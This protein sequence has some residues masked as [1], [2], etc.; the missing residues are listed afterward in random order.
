MPIKESTYTPPFFLT[1]GHTQ[2]LY[3]T[4]FRKIKPNFEYRV[5][6]VTPDL[7]F[8]DVDWKKI[9]SKKCV[10]LSHGMEGNSKKWYISAMSQHFTDHDFDVCAW[11]FR[12]CSGEPNVTLS[13]YHSGKTEDLDLVIQNAINDYDEIYLV[14]F[15]MGGNIS[16]KYVGE[17][18]DT[19][20]PKIKKCAV[21]SVPVDLYGSC[22]E[23]NKTNNIVYMKTFISELKEKM[24]D[25]EKLFPDQVSLENYGDI[26][27]FVDFDNIYT[28]PLNGFLNSDDYCK[29]A[30]SKQ[31][32][33]TV[34]IPTLLV[35]AKNDPFLSK[36][37]YPIKEC[38]YHKFVTLEIPKEGGHISFAQKGGIYYSEQRALEFFLKNV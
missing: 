7:D 37:C 17:R 20:H 4:F 38:K 35:N 15:S 30:S 22:L 36:S 25:K 8:I 34:K 32:I 2:T 5:R 9:N 23:L 13:T 16:L 31:F 6:L 24:E 10:I 3:P 33:A 29:Q 18:G 27:S 21:F 11:N 1:N 12:G 28:A 14:G 26:K 19:I